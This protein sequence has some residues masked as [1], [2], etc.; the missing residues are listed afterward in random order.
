MDRSSLFAAACLLA[1]CACGGGGSIGAGPASGTVFA[2]PPAWPSV[3][4]ALVVTL[5]S[6]DDGTP[7]PGA[8]VT[9]GTVSALT[10]ANGRAVVAAPVVTPTVLVAAAAAY[11]TLHATVAPFQAAVAFKLTKPTAEENAWIAQIDTDRA[12]YGA[13]PLALD[14]YAEETARFKVQDEAARGYYG[15]GDPQTGAEVAALA[16]QS[17]GGIGLYYDLLG[18][19]LTRDWTSVEAQFV[20]EGPP[21]PGQTNHFSNLVSTDASWAGVA[22]AA[23]KNFDPATYG[24]NPMWYYCAGIVRPR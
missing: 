17:R 14:E 12:R 5:T 13:P 8:L 7:I 24:T 6:L 4:P 2:T 3:S 20:A 9:V 1:L 10:D 16:Y 19:Q 15:H 11:A 22:L 23:G 21:P 18:A